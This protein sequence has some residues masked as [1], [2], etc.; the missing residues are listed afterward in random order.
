MVILDTFFIYLL[1]HANIQWVEVQNSAVEAWNDLPAL[2][3]FRY[4][5][6]C[7]LQI[8]GGVEAHQWFTVA[9]QDGAGHVLRRITT[10]SSRKITGTMI[11]RLAFAA[12]FVL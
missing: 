10:L 6:S 3:A 11:S 12:R 7:R 5:G 9:I 1:F 2:A 8:F 4:S